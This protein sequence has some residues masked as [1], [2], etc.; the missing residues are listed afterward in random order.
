VLSR[1]IIGGWKRQTSLSW[2]G[3]DRL[4]DAG[5][6]AP[7]TEI[8]PLPVEVENTGADSV[9][10]AVRLAERHVLTVYDAASLELALRKQLPLATLDRQ[11][12]AAARLEGVAVLP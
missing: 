12:A 2:A 11:L 5:L 1:P 9:R 3:G 8:L 7:L 6:V 4:N 10:D